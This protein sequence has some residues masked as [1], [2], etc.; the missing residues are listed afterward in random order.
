ML[1]EPHPGDD[2]SGSDVARKLCILS[3]LIPNSPALE[4]GYESIPTENLIPS[5]LMNIASG[6]EFIQRLP[7][8]DSHFE[9]MRKTAEDKG[10]VLRY[11]GVI[12]SKKKAVRCGIER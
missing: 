4:K 5:D 3:R 9:Q 6:E 2:L 12:D 10:E 11:I 7:E 1:Q 8:F